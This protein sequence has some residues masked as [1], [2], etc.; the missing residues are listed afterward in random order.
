MFTQYTRPLKF[1][2]DS[3]KGHKKIF[4]IFILGKILEGIFYVVLPIFAK[5]EMDQ[6]VEKNEQLFGFIYLDSFRIFLVILCIIFGIRL[7][8]K[9]LQSF[10]EFV[11]KFYLALHQNAYAAL[12][13][14]RL[15]YIEFGAFLNAK[16]MKFINEILGKSDFVGEHMRMFIGDMITHI[17][18]II[19]IL[20][21]I[22][23]IN[24]WIFVVLMASAC[25]L[26]CID[27]LRQKIAQKY[28]FE[29]DYVYAHKVFIVSQ[30]ISKN[31]IHLISSGGFGKVIDIYKKFNKE[32]QTNIQNRQKSETF[33]SVFSF[34][35]ENITE[36]LVKLF[37]GY[38]IFFAGASVGTMT[39]ML[40]YISRIDQ[41]LSFVRTFRFFR[42]RFSDDL[43]KLDLFLDLTDGQ[44]RLSGEKIKSL[45]NFDTISLENVEF[46]YP[47]FAKY[48]LRYLK[49][50]EERIKSYSRIGSAEKNE[51]HAIEEA[52]KDLQEISPKILQG[53]DLI[54]EKGKSYGIVGKNGAGKTTITSLLQ[55]FFYR[56]QG[57]ILFDKTSVGNLDR[58]FFEKNISVV[59]Q[60]PYII[61]GFSIRE[62]LLLGVEKTPNDQKIW[63]LLE[64]FHLDKKIKKHRQGLDANIGYDNDFSG[65]E[66]QLLTLIR[67]ILQDKPLL[68]MDEGTN[69][70]DAENELMVMNEL[71]KQQKDKIII[72]ITH[73]M[74]TIK[75]ADVI[76]CLQDGK[77]EASGRHDDLLKTENVYHTFW[78]TQVVS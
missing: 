15:R 1:I 55:G 7:L 18:T 70:L 78:D 8:Q 56:F 75:K 43:K 28:Q 21:V 53:V 47:K 67:V 4:Y 27:L 51:L 40:L 2:F 52:R 41:I 3:F 42:D 73:R 20:G 58:S 59:S 17:F 26:Y 11:E 63:E 68:I 54:F 34:S 14:Q 48:E 32:L 5:M 39:M 49:I 29:E 45:K 74:T 77:I 12:L 9:I 6:M 64:K 44:K 57:K 36:I 66:K 30:E 72:F 60:T 71:L 38:S 46:S 61:Q 10:I 76:Y 65:G 16:N 33:L 62:N 24:P 37:I 31:M 22:S 19:G 35:V 69:Q 25:I 50:I 13:Y 23:L